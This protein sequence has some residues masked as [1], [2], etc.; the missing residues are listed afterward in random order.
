MVDNFKDSK[1][2]HKTPVGAFAKPA[3]AFNTRIMYLSNT[4][5]LS[6][7][8]SVIKNRAIPM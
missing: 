3:L 7:T 6:N 4:T 2:G 8:W 1:K 5:R